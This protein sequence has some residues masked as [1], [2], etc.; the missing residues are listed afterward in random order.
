MPDGLKSYSRCVTLQGLVTYP[1]LHQDPV[2]HYRRIQGCLQRAHECMRPLK[3]NDRLWGYC[4]SSE[5]GPNAGF[6]LGTAEAISACRC[7]TICSTCNTTK[8]TISTVAMPVYKSVE[9]GYGH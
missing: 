2:A 5:N 7:N 3:L 8:E 9:Q 1:E 6:E 4:M